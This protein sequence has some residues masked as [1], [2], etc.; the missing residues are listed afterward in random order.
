MN[1]NPPIEPS[2]NRLLSETDCYGLDSQVVA[3]NVITDD[4]R[5]YQLAYAHFTHSELA[6]NPELESR[7]DAPPQRLTIHFSMAVVT[8]VGAALRYLD[9]A[10][11]KAELKYVQRGTL[12]VG[13]NKLGIPAN[14]PVVVSVAITFT[15]ENP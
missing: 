4:R 14:P 8:V 9:K 13:K 2:A 15:K 6:A 3:L 5:G 12:D 11:Q 7:H 10:L 1:T